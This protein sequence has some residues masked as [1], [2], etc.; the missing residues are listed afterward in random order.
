MVAIIPVVT[1]LAVLG[2][3]FMG[4]DSKA[5]P[6][7]AIPEPVTPWNR[8]DSL[9]RKYSAQFGVPWRW[10]KAVMIIESDLGRAPSVA[11]GLERPFDIEQSKSSDGKSWGLMQ[12]TLPTANDLQPGITAVGLNDAETSVRLGTQYLG[13][14]IKRWGINEREKVIRSYNGGPG[15]MN[16]NIGRTWT[17]AYYKKFLTALDRVMKAQPGNEKEI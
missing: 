11:R 16:S 15:F 17:E 4:R 6:G 5:Q 7:N 3:I 2:V 9:I 14:M 12:L 1:A 10:V 13:R 8:W